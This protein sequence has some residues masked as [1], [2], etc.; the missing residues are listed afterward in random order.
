MEKI[1][2]RGLNWTYNFSF[3]DETNYNNRDVKYG[4]RYSKDF[5]RYLN[6]YNSDGKKIISFD[7]PNYIKFDLKVIHKQIDDYIIKSRN[8]K[9][10]NLKN[11]RY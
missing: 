8:K 5:K 6:I 10:N 4:Y 9:L 2:Y 3:K 7:Y 1:L 11:E